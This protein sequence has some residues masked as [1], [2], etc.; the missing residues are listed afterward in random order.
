MTSTKLSQN[1]TITPKRLRNFVFYLHRYLGLVLGLIIVVIGVTGTL[2]MFDAE[3]YHL[4]LGQRLTQVTP[5][6]KP[7]SLDVL[8][9]KV[10]AAYSSRPYL[11]VAAISPDYLQTGNSP[12][13]V[14][15][16]DNNDISLGTSKQKNH[17][18]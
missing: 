13:S 12:T 6:G 5:Q 11:K 14:S 4:V 10:Q 17:Q 8:V 1:Q 16:S 15:I 18:I 9:E 3:V 2:W 7:L